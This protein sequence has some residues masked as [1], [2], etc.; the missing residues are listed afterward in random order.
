MELRV[1]ARAQRPTLVEFSAKTDLMLGD[2][3][4]SQAKAEITERRLRPLYG[5]GETERA[6]HAAELYGC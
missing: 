5:E 3:A 6:G 1:R 4:S 2:M